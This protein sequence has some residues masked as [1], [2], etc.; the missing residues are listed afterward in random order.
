MGGLLPEAPD[1]ASYAEVKRTYDFAPAAEEICR[2]HGISPARLSRAASGTHPVFL[3]DDM[4]IKAFAPPW[5][6]DFTAER[7]AL[8]AAGGG[9]FPEIIHEGILEGWPYLVTTRTPGSPAGEIWHLLP[10]GDKE[11]LLCDLGVMLRELH[12]AAVPPGPGTDWAAFASDLRATL[13]SRNDPP[14]AEWRDWLLCRTGRDPGPFEPVLLHA[15]VTWDHVFVLRGEGG[16]RLTGLIDF[17]DAMPGH[18]LYEFG[19]PL[20]YMCFGQPALTWSLLSGY[21]LPKCRDTA[22]RVLACSLLHRFGSLGRWLGKVPAEDGR[23]FEEALFGFDLG[24]AGS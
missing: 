20:L 18:P 22:E 8:R 21:G 7:A 24:S 13:E 16:I 11:S 1:P 17:G 6:E 14:S 19:A 10:F 5:P 4:A 23:A 3:T 2:R 15:D 12:R 9:S